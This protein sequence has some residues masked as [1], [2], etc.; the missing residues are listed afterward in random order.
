MLYEQTIT[1]GAP[2]QMN[3]PGRFFLLDSTGVEN[4]LTV[5]LL[6]G[7]SPI[8]GQIPGARRGLKLGVE[9]GFDDVRIEAAGNTT[10]RFF[11]TFE[12]VSISTTDGAAVSVPGGV[13][14]TNEIGAPVP[15][16]HTG[17]V[18]LT[19]DNVGVKSPGVLAGLVDVAV[20]AGAWAMVVAAAVG[21]VIQREVIIRS[22][23]ANAEWLRVGG[24][25][26]AANN[27]HEIMPGESMTINSL[28]AVYVWNNS[29]SSQ[30]VSVLINQRL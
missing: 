7:G 8:F 30:S 22:L 23:F 14:V 9:A 3:V 19:A 2:L 4:A 20:P 27:G 24:A 17:T 15:V 13:V 25:D 5:T 26:C 11:A 29:A 6:R 10:V 21:G 1:A 28:A 12:N 16:V 18:E